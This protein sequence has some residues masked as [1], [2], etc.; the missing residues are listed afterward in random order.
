MAGPRG[1][2]LGAVGGTG[3]FS[4]SGRGAQGAQWDPPRGGGLS[5]PEERKRAL[6]NRTV[7]H[8]VLWGTGFGEDVRLCSQVATSSASRTS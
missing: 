7:L 5:R 3:E 6:V 8:R 2:F 4:S 1:A